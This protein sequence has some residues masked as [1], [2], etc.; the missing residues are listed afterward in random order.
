M[1]GS[2]R[3]DGY[4]SGAPA[5]WNPCLAGG[6][7]PLVPSAMGCLDPRFTSQFYFPDG[8]NRG[9]VN[10]HPRVF[11]NFPAYAPYAYAYPV[12]VEAPPAQPAEVEEAEPPAPTIFE[13][14]AQA[15]PVRA[16][17]PAATESKASP[18][19]SAGPAETT[20][21]I[22]TVLIF[23]DGHQEEVLNYAIV[24]QTLYDLGTF[25]SHKIPLSE[26]NLKAT[27]KANEERG[28]EFNL[29]ASVIAH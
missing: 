25:V 14:R 18:V 26:L 16:A 4:F 6:V 29:P 22:P 7:S 27:I 17:A 24:G 8:R 20:E 13:R 11:P 2:T 9:A 19:A 28:L 10:L 15:A 21:K 1:V 5:Y 23:R 12:A 3:P